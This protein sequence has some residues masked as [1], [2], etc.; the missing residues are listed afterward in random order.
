M[1]TYSISN[2]SPGQDYTR[3]IVLPKLLVGMGVSPSS[4]LDPDHPFLLCP[5]S[6]DFSALYR[7]MVG[8]VSETKSDGPMKIIIGSKPDHPF[9]ENL[10]IPMKCQRGQSL[11]MHLVDTNAFRNCVV[12]E[13]EE[14]SD[15]LAAG[16]L[17]G[18]V[19]TEIDGAEVSCIADVQ[20]I[21]ADVLQQG[22]REIQVQVRR[23][24]VE[25]K[26]RDELLGVLIEGVVPGLSEEE[27]AVMVTHTVVGVSTLELPFD[28]HVATDALSRLSASMKDDTKIVYLRTV[29]FLARHEEDAVKVFACRLLSLSVN[30]FSQ[31]QVESTIVPNLLQLA[32]ESQGVD[33]QYEAVSRISKLLLMFSQGDEI[34]RMLCDRLRVYVE[35]EVNEITLVLV[36]GL[37]EMIP[38]AVDEV[39]SGFI[40]DS[41][42]RLSAV[43]CSPADEEDDRLR[44][45][46]GRMLLESY[47][48][49]IGS[50]EGGGGDE[51]VDQKIS[52]GLGMLGAAGVLDTKSAL[53]LDK[54]KQQWAAKVGSS[55][56]TH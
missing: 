5:G 41:L 16:I 46:L 34:C 7:V 25:Q 29:L 40:L 24:E 23:Y 50:G 4:I 43:V 18:D 38:S 54:M 26:T 49:F 21:L 47:N 12:R 2:S 10:V 37:C 52:Q 17:K 44:K 19:V 8:D 51:L 6:L 48:V 35:F 14:K 33:V 9:Y 32:H 22:G 30:Y 11:G 39:R 28:Y 55:T 20:D 45:Q 31:E 1:A 36:E 13:I 56:P 42:L 15:A 53:V 27:L 3:N